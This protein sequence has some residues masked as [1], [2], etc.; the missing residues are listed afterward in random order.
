MS[1][2]LIMNLSHKD[3]WTLISC[4]ANLVGIEN[5]TLVDK[6]GIIGPAYITRNGYTDD[7]L[8]WTHDAQELLENYYSTNLDNICS[9]PAA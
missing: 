1:G 3:Q 5:L 6:K 4:F 9:S 8:T 2:V 7:I